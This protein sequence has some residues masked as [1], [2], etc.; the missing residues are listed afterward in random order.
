MRSIET[1]LNANLFLVKMYKNRVITIV[2]LKYMYVPPGPS[3]SFILHTYLI[4][5]HNIIFYVS[6]KFGPGHTLK[7]K[8]VMTLFLLILTG[9][10]F[11]LI[12][13][14]MIRNMIKK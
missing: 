14:C 10:K 9:N 13:V 6:G 1:C 3:K 4:F 8:M 5:L 2:S 11:A 7:L 12:H